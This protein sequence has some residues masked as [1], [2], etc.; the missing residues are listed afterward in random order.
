MEEGEDVALRGVVIITLG[1]RDRTR[2][3]LSG[4]DAQRKIIRIVLVSD[5]QRFDTGEFVQSLSQA[6]LG[7]QCFEDGD[8]GGGR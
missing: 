4:F 5:V 7:S 2:F 8:G 3:V 1:I 6:G